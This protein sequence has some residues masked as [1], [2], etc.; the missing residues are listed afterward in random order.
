MG[1][2]LLQARVAAMQAG[3]PRGQRRGARAQVRMGFPQRN[4]EGVEGV[5]F[6]GAECR[7]GAGGFTCP[8]CR[9]RVVELP[10]R[11]LA[12]RCTAGAGECCPDR[13]TADGR[14]V[15]PRPADGRRPLLV[16]RCCARASLAR[17]PAG[18][19]VLLRR[20]VSCG[21]SAH[22]QPEAVCT[23]VIRMHKPSQ[24]GAE[25]HHA[26]PEGLTLPDRAA[27]P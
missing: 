12:L 22:I 14:G 8:R 13:P 10:S 15:L 2:T 16:M 27:A 3:G 19:G 18:S 25:S 26:D 11:C 9:A 1:Q 23:H 5:A 7:L 4:A 21:R 24:I 6:L 17:T 20:R